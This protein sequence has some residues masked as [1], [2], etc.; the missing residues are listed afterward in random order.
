SP[1]DTPEDGRLLDSAASNARPTHGA[2]VPGATVTDSPTIRVII[3]VDP[4]V[5]AGAPWIRVL[6]V[7]DHSVGGMVLRMFFELQPDIEVVG[8]A[9]DG[10]EGV[11]MARQR[12]AQ[13]RLS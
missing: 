1:A 4:S 6:I 7:D 10:S 5:V 13:V 9:T 12:G 2:A 8:E 11:A 3:V